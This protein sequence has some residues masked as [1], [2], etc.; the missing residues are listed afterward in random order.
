MH[1]MKPFARKS[2]FSLQPYVSYLSRV[3]ADEQR[4][5]V[6]PQILVLPR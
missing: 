1:S 3:S 2:D 6:V 4:R 5:D